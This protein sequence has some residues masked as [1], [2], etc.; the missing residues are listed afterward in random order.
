MPRL[1]QL[2]TQYLATRWEG[3]PEKQLERAIHLISRG[4]LAQGPYVLVNQGHAVV[5]AIYS[6]VVERQNLLGAIPRFAAIKDSSFIR[7]H[8]GE[9]RLLWAMAAEEA[10]SKIAVLQRKWNEPRLIKRLTE[11]LLEN[12]P[13]LKNIKPIRYADIKG[14]Y[15]TAPQSSTLIVPEEVRL[16]KGLAITYAARGLSL[17]PVKE[18]IRRSHV[19][20]VVLSDIVHKKQPLET[21][22]TALFRLMLSSK[23]NLDMRDL[24][25]ELNGR[26]RITAADMHFDVHPYFSNPALTTLCPLTVT[27]PSREKMEREVHYQL[28]AQAEAESSRN[29]TDARYALLDQLVPSDPLAPMD[30]VPS[31]WMYGPEIAETRL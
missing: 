22:V 25:E 18:F 26:P 5:E 9:C 12:I 11:L 15:H 28:A 4:V 10:P 19:S 16:I 27:V 8:D 3:I 13:E 17:D 14:D 2:L 1:V 21:F 6:K 20:F 31:T 29:N 30:D 24:Q 7:A 23:A